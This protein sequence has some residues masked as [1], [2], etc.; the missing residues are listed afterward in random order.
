MTARRSLGRKEENDDVTVSRTQTER[1]VCCCS[2]MLPAELRKD[3][4]T[5][6]TFNSMM[7]LMMRYH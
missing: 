2:S 7:G 1:C 3:S 4:R 5:L 6:R